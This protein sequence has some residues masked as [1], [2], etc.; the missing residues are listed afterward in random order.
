MTNWK[1]MGF[2]VFLIAFSPVSARA[3]CAFGPFAFFPDRNDVV[4]VRVDSDGKGLCD[5]SFR[6]GPGYHFTDVR[7]IGGAPARHC[8]DA[9]PKPFRL[10]AAA[11]F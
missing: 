3:V 7:P 9:G 4:H 5:L 2:A 1:S 6:E 8:R 10:R 11:K